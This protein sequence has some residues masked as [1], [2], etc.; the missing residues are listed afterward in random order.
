MTSKRIF[1]NISCFSTLFQ[2]KPGFQKYFDYKVVL[3]VVCFATALHKMT[4]VEM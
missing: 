4:T 1:S 2:Q 3:S